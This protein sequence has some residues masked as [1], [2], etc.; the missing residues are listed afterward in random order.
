MK[1][2]IFLFLLLSSQFAY[3]E[4][5]FEYG[6]VDNPDAVITNVEVF[7]VVAVHVNT[8][9]ATSPFKLRA[10]AATSDYVHIIYN[11]DQVISSTD[12]LVIDVCIQ[13]LGDNIAMLLLDNEVLEVYQVLPDTAVYHHIHRP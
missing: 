1:K 8:T 5:G 10:T 7:D 13:Q 6:C 9:T 11:D 3:G 12:F 4:E 2:C